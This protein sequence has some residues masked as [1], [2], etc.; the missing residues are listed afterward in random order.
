MKHVGR[1]LFKDNLRF[2]QLWS[3]VSVHKRLKDGTIIVVEFYQSFVKPTVSHCK[4]S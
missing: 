4:L 3:D 2:L 1:F